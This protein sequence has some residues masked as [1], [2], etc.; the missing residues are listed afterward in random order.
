MGP[1]S[2]RF[3]AAF[4]TRGVIACYGL[5]SADAVSSGEVL[6]TFFTLMFAGSLHRRQVLLDNGAVGKFD[7]L[8]E[9]SSAKAQG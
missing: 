4:H 5:S 7:F 1:S 6:V 9:E 2:F 8:R 3:F